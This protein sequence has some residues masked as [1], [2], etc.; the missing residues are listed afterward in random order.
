LHSWLD[1]ILDERLLKRPATLRFCFVL[2]IRNVCQDFPSNAQICALSCKDFQKKGGFVRKR[3]FGLGLGD[4][5]AR[6]QER[7]EADASWTRNSVS[8]VFA[9]VRRGWFHGNPSGQPLARI[10]KVLS[11]GSLRLL[12]GG[13]KATWLQ[14]CVEIFFC[15]SPFFWVRARRECGNRVKRG[16]MGGTFVDGN[17]S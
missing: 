8:C 7:T 15:F 17:E 4:L 1:F 2:A 16:G 3:Y 5:C 11:G 10:G 13:K 9:G 14:I 6:H 12:A